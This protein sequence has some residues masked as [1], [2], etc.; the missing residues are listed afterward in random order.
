MRPHVQTF[1]DRAT[2][3]ATHLVSDP[4]TGVAAVVDPVLDFDPKS[5]KLSTRS[6]DE[7][8]A[9]VRDQG[10]KLAF[11][12][13]THAHADHLSAGDYI[14]KATGAE[15]VIGANIREVQKTFIP[16]FEADDVSPDG[17]VFDVLLGEGDVLRMGEI[18]IGVLH[19]PGHTPA[20]VTYLIGDAAFVGDT[21]FMPDYGTARAD[22]PG[23][24]AATLFRSIRKILALP[25]QTR[26]FVGHDYLPEGRETFR[27]ETT[28][29][30]Q[31]AGNVHV[32][33][34][35]SEAEFVA[36][37]TA[38]D[39][40][41]AAP[42]LILPSLQV[43]IRAGALPPPTPRGHVFLRLPVTTP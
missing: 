43:N 31:R 16:M 27:W 22:F 42:T 34:G 21:L 24:D 35:V 25:P 38:R 10:L 39:A 18:E 23:G 32:H 13:E 29:A 5:A 26:I 4:A 20:C 6:A 19:T 33:D 8:L 28:V 36:M 17:R 41:L 7:V 9:A 30:E 15:L 1:F 12:L 40:T 2:S 3:T 11:V 14:R 37:R